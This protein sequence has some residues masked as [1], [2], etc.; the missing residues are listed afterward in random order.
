MIPV[1]AIPVAMTLLL[2]SSMKLLYI[3][4]ALLYGYYGAD[5]LFKLGVFSPDIIHIN[6]DGNCG[7]WVISHAIY[8]YQD[9]Y[10][11]VR[12]WMAIQLC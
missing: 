4:S 2:T 1:A 10:Q 3:K 5:K 9:S 12:Q 7:F 6:A 8:S 11:L